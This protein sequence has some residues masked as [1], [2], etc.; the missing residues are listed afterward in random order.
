MLKSEQYDTFF[1]TRKYKN[2]LCISFKDML[3]FL[4][5]ESEQN[6]SLSTFFNSLRYEP[7]VKVVIF[8][9][10][11]EQFDAC[12]DL[13]VF[14]SW[15]EIREYSNTVLNIC[16]QFDQFILK[17][18]DTDKIFIMTLT[19]KT[20]FRDF[21]L[22]LACDYRIATNDFMVRQPET[23]LD[24]ILKDSSEYLLSSIIG[25]LKTIEIMASGNDID[26]N[27]LMTLGLV[28]EIVP[29]D[30]PTLMDSS[31]QAAEK[32]E[33]L[34]ASRLK[35]LKKYSAN[36]LANY[37]EFKNKRLLDFITHKTSRSR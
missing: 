31:L 34:P 23:K 4:V 13:E 5:S 32:F 29:C 2:I 24:L 28:D 22:A 11:F 37:L 17:L 19:G 30:Q 15:K 9:R 6:K 25:E 20:D 7:D 16:N 8:C 21:T 35:R 33:R 14:N 36:E 1:E 26:A 10:S 12:S 27:E 18:I 3:D